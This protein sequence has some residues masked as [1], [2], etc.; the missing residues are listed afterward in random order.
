M[1]RSDQMTLA[2]LDALC[3]QRLASM[4][5][6]KAREREGTRLARRRRKPGIRVVKRGRR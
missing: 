6:G 3:R 2:E 5:P 1:K 4:P